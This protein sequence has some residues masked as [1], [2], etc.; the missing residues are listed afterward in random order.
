MSLP[1]GTVTFLFTDIEGSTKLWEQHPEA[2]RPALA[3]HDMLMR[4]AIGANDGT[5]FKTVGDAFCAAFATAPDALQAALSAQQSIEAE[6]WNLPSPL[7]VRMGLHTGA[8]EERGGDYFGQPLNRVARLMSAG[9]GGQILLSGVTQELILDHLPASVTL[10]DLGQRRLKD[11]GRPEHVYQVVHPS[12]PADF[13]PLKSLDN[14]ELPNNLPQQ[15]T[16]FIGREKQ[17]EEVRAL[18]GRTRLLTLTGA[19]GSGKTRLSLQIAADLLDQYFDGVWLVE[20]GSLTDPALV[21]QAVANVLGIQEEPGKSVIKT[22]TE[23]F[24]AKRLLLI[25]DNCEHLVAACASLATDLLRSCPDVHILAS[26]REPLNVSGEQSFR[27]PSLSLP[28]PKGIQTV[29][30]LSQFEA[31]QLFIE[32]AQAVQPR[33]VVTNANAPAV[34]QVCYHLDGIPL[35]IELAAARARSLTVEEI[36]ARL[37]NRFRL[38]TGGSRTAQP[39]QQTLRALI[40]WSYDLLAEKEKALL[41]HLSVFAGGWTLQAAEKVVSGGD[42]QEALEDFEVLDLL[43]ALVDKSLVAYEE[44]YHKAEEAGESRYRLLETVRQYAGER[45]QERGDAEEAR[46]A[47]LAWCVALADEAGPHLQGSDGMAWLTRLETE[48]DNLR[49]G[50]MWAG[51]SSERAGQGLHLAGV[52]MPFWFIRG[53][54]SEARSQLETALGWESAEGGTRDR[55]RALNALGAFAFRNGDWQVARRVWEQALTISR[56]IGNRNF[57]VANLSNLGNIQVALGDFEAAVSLYEQALVINREIGNRNGEAANLY[58]LGNVKSGHG[59]WEAARSYFEQALAI[60]REIG[61]ISSQ[62]L[63]LQLLGSVLYK[64]GYQEMAHS[65]WEQALRI[66]HEIGNRSGEA[67]IFHELG[68]AALDQGALPEARRHFVQ[69]L[70]LRRQLG[71]HVGVLDALE[72]WAA[73]SLAEGD[74]ARAARLLSARQ[75]E[76]E[77]LSVAWAPDQKDRHEKILSAARSALGDEAFRAAWDLGQTMTLEQ[78]MEYALQETGA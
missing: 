7:L 58:A 2:M 60:D 40:A 18:M 10:R 54:W 42:D 74:T 44:G 26:S 19:G 69:C 70:I 28:D 52:L 13:P 46:N 50:L 5:V 63:T 72:D 25:L 4:A 39:R 23:W 14:P 20:L 12:L 35:A 78:A 57:E 64:Q 17:V 37:D 47:H 49:A 34:A 22:V 76:Y 71:E 24:K 62:V 8:A 1:S 9:H 67:R 27:V 75:R 29:E 68:M 48:H 56:E 16:S 31:V 36:N 51:T 73:L 6:P 65:H 38:L 66:S 21:P 53:H 77:N 32:R 30:A 41:C 59:E 15:V 33:F 45:L 55:A 43:T 61:N 3:R 11:L